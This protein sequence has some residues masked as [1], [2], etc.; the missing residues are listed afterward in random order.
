MFGRKNTKVNGFGDFV[1]GNR[2]RK[3]SF[4][5]KVEILFDW[6]PISKFLD[7]ALSRNPDGVGNPSY[8]ALLMFKILLLQKWFKL[9]NTVMGPWSKCCWITPDSFVFFVL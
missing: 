8:P 4:L 9:S 3:P 1:L 2:K 6:A 5:D 7:E